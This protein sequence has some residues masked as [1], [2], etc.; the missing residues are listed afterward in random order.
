MRSRLQITPTDLYFML[1]F[2]QMITS[3]ILLLPLDANYV[4]RTQM[5]DGC[6]VFLPY[7]F[8]NLILLVA[9]SIHC[10]RNFHI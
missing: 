3:L 1:S 10:I 5:A 4:L 7:I 9:I 8:A 6:Q 2:T